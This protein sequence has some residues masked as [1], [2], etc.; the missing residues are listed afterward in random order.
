MDISFIIPVYNA[1]KYVQRCVLSIFDQDFSQ[2]TFEVIVIDDGSTDNSLLLTKQLA[3]EYSNILVISKENGGAASARNVGIEQA[4]GEYLVFIDADDYFRSHSMRALV[5][6]GKS[7][8]L[9]ILYYRLAIHYEDETTPYT[10]GGDYNGM[11]IN[12]I[13]SGVECYKRG[14]QAS[15]MCGCM[16]KREILFANNLRFTNRRFGEDSLLSY[17][18]TAFANKVM[19]LND[20]PY[21]YFKN[22]DSVLRSMSINQHL[23]QIEDTL[24]VGYD[25]QRL[26]LEIN[27]IKLSDILKRYS[28]NIIFGAYLE[29]W[30]SRKEFKYNNLLNSFITKLKEQGRFPFKGPFFSFKKWLVVKILINNEYMYL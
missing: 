6:T 7:N 27:N 24:G 8:D 15:S 28:V 26:S 29:M 2:G 23:R 22:N 11:P 12:N 16:V 3:Q 5:D 4:S 1:E 20:A 14:F 19:F 30:K 18:I 10:L 21:I 25:L 13:M 17:C 9:D